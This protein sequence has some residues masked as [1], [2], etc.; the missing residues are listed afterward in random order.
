MS[1]TALD[2]IRHRLDALEQTVAGIGH[3][4]A[5]SLDDEPSPADKAEIWLSRRKQAERWDVSI[6]TVER[7]GEDPKLGMPPEMEINGRFYR[8]L[9]KLAAWERARVQRLAGRDTAPAAGELTNQ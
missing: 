2:L 8:A 6:R 1:D 5:P 7:W 4:G 9:S 3:N